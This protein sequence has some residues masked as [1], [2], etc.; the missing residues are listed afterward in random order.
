MSGKRFQV[1]TCEGWPINQAKMRTGTGCTKAGV[2]ATVIDTLH[3]C[4][5]VKTYRSED[6][7][8]WPAHGGYRGR[9]EAVRDARTHAAYLNG[10]YDG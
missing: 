8:P 1:A 7:G 10:L 3:L 5:E 9:A 2:S 4:A 6:R